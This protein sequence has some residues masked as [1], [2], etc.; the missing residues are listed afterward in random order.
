MVEKPVL[1]N[2][3]RVTGQREIRPVWNNAQRVNHQN[4]LTHP[5]PKRNFVP[6]AVATKSGQVLVNATK[7]SSPRPAASISTTRLVNTVAP[8]PKVNDALPITYSY[9]KAHSPVNNV[10]TAGPKAVVS[11]IEGNGENAIKSS[12]CWIWHMTRNKSFLTDYQEIDGGFVAFGGS[13][14][15][16]GLTCLFA[17][18]TIDESNLWHRRLGHINF[19]TMKKLVRGN[20]VRVLPSKLF[21]NVHTCVACQKGKFS[22]VFFLATK[23][24]TSGILKTFITGIE[25]QINHKVKIIRCDNGTEFK[26]NDMNQFCGMKGIKREFSVARTPQQNRVAKRKNMTLIEAARTMLAD[27]LLPT[28]FWAEAVNTA[29]YVQNRVLVTKPHNKTPYELLHGRPPSISFMRPFGCPVTILNTLDPLG[30]FDGKANE[31]FLVGY[32]INSKAFRVFNTRT[33]KVEENMHIT[34]L[35]NKP[36]IVGSR[37]DWLFDID[38]LTNSMNYEPV[39]AGNQTNRNAEDAVVDDAGK[40]TNENPTNEGERNGQEKEGGAS[41]KEGDQNVQDFRVEL[42]NL[43]VQQKEGLVDLPIGGRSFTWMNK[44]GTK[45]SKLDRFL[46]SEDVTI[47]LPDVRITALDRLWS[48]HNPI[49]LHIDK[50]DFGPTPFKLY[51]SWLLR[52]G[53]DNLIKEEWELLDSNL[54]CHEKFRRLKDKIKQWSNN[55]KT[56]ERNRKTVALEEINSIEKRIDEGSAMPSDNDHRLILLQEIEKIDKFASMDIIQKA[57]VKWDIEGDEN[58]KFFHGLINQKRRNQMI[59]GIMV[60]GNWITNPCLI[61]DAFLQFYKRKFQA[62]DSQVMFSNLPH[63]HSLNCMD[64]ETLERQVTLEEIKEAV[65]DCGSSKAPGPDGY[66]FAFVKKYWGTIQKDLYDFVNLFFASC[67]M[68]NGANSSFFTLIP[69]VNNPTLI[70]DFR[71]ISL[72]GIHYKIIAKILA[73]RLSKVI[74]KIV[75]KEQSAFIAGRQ[76]LDGPVILSEIIEWYKKRKKKLLIFKVD[77]EKAF[78]SIS[79]N[80]L[81]H[82]LDSFGFGNKWCSWIKACLNSSRAS[83][84]INGSP[85]SE[86]SIKRGLRQGDPLS[87]F[88]FILVME[89]LHNAFEEAVGNG[90]ITGVNIKNSTINVSHLFYADD[91]IITTDWNAKDMDNIIRVLHVFYLASGLK[92]NIHKSNIYGIGVNKDEVLSMASNAGCIAGDIPFNYLGLPIGSNMKSIA[93]WKT[94]VDRFHMRLSSWKANLLSIGGRLTLIKSVLGSLGIYYLSIFRAPESVLQDLERIRANFFWGGNKDKNKMAWV[95]WPIILNS[96]D[97]GGL[98]IGSLKAFNLALLQKWRW[99]LLSSPNAL[100]VQVIKAYHGQ[101]GGFDTNGCSFKGIW[102]NIVGTSNFLH[103]KGIILSNTFRFKAGCGTR[104]RFWKDIW[105]GETPLF[106]RYNRL[107]HLD[108]DKDCLIIDRINNGQWSWNWSRTNL[109]VRN[110]AYLCDMLNEIGQLNIDVNED[111][112]TWSLG[113]NGT[114]T[115]KDARYRIDQNILPTLAHATTWDKSIPRKVNVFMWRLSL[116]RLPHRLNLSSRGMD[117][118]AI[119]CPSCNANVESANHV[120]FECDIATDMWKLVFRWCDIPLFQASSWDSFNDWIISWH[121]SKEKKHRFYVITTSVLW[122]LWRYRNSV[123]FNSQPLR[124]SDLFDN[125]RFSSFSWLHNR[126]H[127][128]LSWNDWLMY[129]LSITRNGNG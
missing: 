125:V 39:T 118:P 55:I 122:W 35:E 44:A 68:P 115:V 17:K 64:R 41:N 76:I 108:Q 27:S 79:W 112:C 12:A 85:T 30:K 103:S 97:K 74:D 95:K 116:D 120:F 102:A 100:W 69:K 24:E 80:Y 126:D 111:T 128:K 6:T 107:Y 8:K 106:T 42:D 104:I 11:A 2:K 40:K 105:V 57:H 47:R 75:S 43:P 50:T 18:A 98:N 72:I 48:D 123:T 7:Q 4:K 26:N 99:R 34:F 124:K 1:N 14:K 63:S 117:I 119:S 32:S 21:E 101:E 46:I 81:I 70:T 33:R 31:G 52:D 58:S 127:M 78:D 91:V 60:E 51:N 36:N 10:T 62:Q 71:P 88:L 110:L 28:T 61:K 84:L 109:G 53:F 129:P 86:F 87:P 15:G 29:C 59:N 92:I 56:L 82:I 20:L 49:L 93:S 38:L 65:W 16:G 13:P 121:A 94:L 114:F 9:F 77:F 19:K 67:V 83:I 96:F 3:G 45:L 89:G 90:L 113:P 66:S 25:N 37:P 73:N 5:H 54:K 22:W 23:D